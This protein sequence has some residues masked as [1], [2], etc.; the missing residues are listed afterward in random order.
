MLASPAALAARA[1]RATHVIPLRVRELI[2]GALIV[3]TALALIY[4]G[5]LLALAAAWGGAR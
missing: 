3:G 4:S 1:R 5:L 2:A